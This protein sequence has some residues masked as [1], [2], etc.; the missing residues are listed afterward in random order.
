M[1]KKLSKKEQRRKLED[2]IFYSLENFDMTHGIGLWSRTRGELK[3]Y[4]NYLLKLI[5][6]MKEAKIS[7]TP[8]A[9]Y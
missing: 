6:A 2:R 8:D 7:S 5:E 9:E 3:H 4:S 1:A